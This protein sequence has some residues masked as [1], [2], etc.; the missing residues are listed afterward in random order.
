MNARLQGCKI[1][2]IRRGNVEIVLQPGVEPKEF[3]DP[4]GSAAVEFVRELR[5]S[6]SNLSEEAH[7]D[8]KIDSLGPVAGSPFDG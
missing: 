1:K 7:L 6:G 8:K 5:K 2:R 3:C 4:A